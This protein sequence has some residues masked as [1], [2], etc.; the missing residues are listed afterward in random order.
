MRKFYHYL[1]LSPLLLCA[2]VFG[3][4]SA[5]GFD[6]T[7]ISLSTAGSSDI[8]LT[9]VPDRT[10]ECWFQVDDK[11][12]SANK[13]VIYEEG[14]RHNGFNI[15]VHSNTLYVGGWSAN[16]GWTAGTYLTTTAISDGVWHHVA[17][18]LEGGTST[19]T[20]DIF[21]GYLDGVEFGSGQGV[22]VNT[23]S[24]DIGWANQNGR[25]QFHDGD[26]D[27]ADDHYFGG[28]LDDFKIWNEA[29]TADEIREGMNTQAGGSETNLV[30]YY[31]FDG[32]GSSVTDRA[33]SHTGTIAGTEDRST[34]DLYTNWNTGNGSTDWSNASN[35]DNG[36]PGSSSSGLAKIPS[37]GTQ[38][39][40]TTA[41]TGRSLQ[42]ENGATL[43]IDPDAALTLSGSVEVNG[44]SGLRLESDATSTGNFLDG[45]GISY[46]NSGSVSVERYMDSGSGVYLEGYHY[47]SSPISSHATFGDMSELYAYRES[48][49]TWL[50]HTDVTDGFSTFSNAIGYAIRYATDVTKTYTG[51]LNTGDFTVAVTSTNHGGNVFEH[52]NLLGNPYGA[53]ISADALVDNNSS[54][55]N[56][57]V[58][59][60]NGVDYGTYNTSLDAGTAGSLGVAPDGNIAVGQGFYVDAS[61]S[62]NVTFTNSM[63]GT[64]SNIFFRK[65]SYPSLRLRATNAEGKS[66]LLLTGHRASSF[67]ADEYDSFHLP[68]NGALNFTTHIDGKSYDIESV[69]NITARSFELEVAAA[70]SGL[71]RFEMVEQ[72]DLDE[73]SYLLEDKA[74]QKITDLAV[75][76]YEAMVSTEENSGRFLLRIVPKHNSALQ[77]W[78]HNGEISAVLDAEETIE[79]VRLLGLD[80]KEVFSG[81]STQISNWDQLAGGVYLL[82]LETNQRTEV[83]KVIR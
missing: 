83:Q 77:M 1:L 43:Q 49:L 8:N 54:V 72:T 59:F 52:F 68:G 81:N 47:I 19:L 48:D 21:K 15:Y 55:L 61:T 29:R 39:V 4:G 46:K 71:V 73:M 2:E 53:S 75:H 82:Q 41:V 50:H 76:S 10:I 24:G 40:I 16:G 25:T 23:H 31:D 44:A 79:T 17:L 22:S 34:S 64:D 74:T 51:S 66:D 32:T 35:W 57:T 36:V 28:K 20:A 60:W 62:G 9:S 58:Y 56:A 26:S 13:Q 5:L 45:G 70:A 11:S 3:Q 78:V 37:G 42:I 67:E 33:M 38:P 63:R 27:S 80:G 14:G 18:T 69:P 65:E 30:L 12:I 6:G 7:S